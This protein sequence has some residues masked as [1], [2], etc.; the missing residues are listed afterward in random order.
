[1]Q[2]RFLHRRLNHRFEML[3]GRRRQLDATRG[4]N[5]DLGKQSSGG[6][7]LTILSL[8]ECTPPH[9]RMLQLLFNGIATPLHISIYS[10]KPHFASSSTNSHQNLDAASNFSNTNSSVII[11]QCLTVVRLPQSLISIR[12][13][14]QIYL[15]V[16]STSR[17]RNR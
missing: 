7:A 13:P 14:S 5:V 4:P 16:S 17:L 12:V 10:F 2:L 11:L 3:N 6:R 1:M 9:E 8:A 15:V